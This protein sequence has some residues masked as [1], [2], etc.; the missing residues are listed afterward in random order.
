MENAQ[1]ERVLVNHSQSIDKLIENEREN[2]KLLMTLINML[3]D[4]PARAKVDTCK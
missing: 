1:I 2:G 3:N 4:Q